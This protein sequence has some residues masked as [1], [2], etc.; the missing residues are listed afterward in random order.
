MDDGV[1][2][3]HQP[4]S[5]VEH[6]G[7]DVVQT[8]GAQQWNKGLVVGLNGDGLAQDVV[9]E[10]LTCQGFLLYLCIPRFSLCHGPRGVCYWFPT[11][12][13]VDQAISE[14]NLTMRRK[15]LSSVVLVGVFM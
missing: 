15:R 11:C 12:S 4:E 10:A 5:K 6:S 13:Q 7:W 2:K 3:A 1:V 9:R 14:V 8:F